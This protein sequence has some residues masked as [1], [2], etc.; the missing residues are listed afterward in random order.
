MEKSAEPLCANEGRFMGGTKALSNKIIHERSV[1]L[2]T[3][4]WSVKTRE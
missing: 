4:V 3:C 2:L 1:P